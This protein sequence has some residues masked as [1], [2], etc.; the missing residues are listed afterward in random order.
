[1]FGSEELTDTSFYYLPPSHSNCSQDCRSFDGS[2]S[3]GPPSQHCHNW[4]PES[5]A[6]IG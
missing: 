4:G 2:G 3:P 5:K 1:M 6:V